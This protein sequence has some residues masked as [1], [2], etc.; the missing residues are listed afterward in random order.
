VCSLV[1]CEVRG[2]IQNFEKHD[3][4]EIN[5]EVQFRNEPPPLESQRS[6]N[7]AIFALVNFSA[8]LCV[9]ENAAHEI[10]NNR[11]SSIQLEDD[12]CLLS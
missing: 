9:Q 11:R 8:H 12:A 7:V 5:V 4:N 3:A 6:T 2:E 1:V 10:K